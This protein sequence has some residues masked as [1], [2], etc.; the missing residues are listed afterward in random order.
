VLVCARVRGKLIVD[1]RYAVIISTIYAAEDVSVLRK[2]LLVVFLLGTL[3][4]GAELLLLGHT[5]A[6]QQLIPLGM[7]TVSLVLLATRMFV[8]GR[9]LLH[10]FRLFMVLFVASGALGI[11]LHY[12]SN[13]EFELE[14]NPSAEGRELVWESLTGAMPALAPGTM[15]QLGLIGLLYTY[16]HPIFSVTRK[17]EASS[18][19]EHD[20]T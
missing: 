14:M 7:I 3:G 5:E 9:N 13:V 1:F 17:P 18:P 16:R 19:E 4:T 2:M 6:L 10:A 20:D 15:V 11:Y 12:Q 8:G